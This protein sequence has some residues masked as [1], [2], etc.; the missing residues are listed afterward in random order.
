MTAI[1]NVFKGLSSFDYHKLMLKKEVIIY[2]CDN[3]SI[4]NIAFM[5]GKNINIFLDPGT[6]GHMSKLSSGSNLGIRG[7]VSTGDRARGIA[8]R[9]YEKTWRTL[10]GNPKQLAMIA[11]VVIHEMRHALY[12]HLRPDVFWDL[13][14]EHSAQQHNSSGWMES[15]MEVSQYVTTNAL[16]FVAE[17]FTGTMCGTS[18][19]SKVL[20]GY[21]ALGGP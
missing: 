3:F 13:K 10:L 21:Q 20:A 9:R 4:K 18:Y 5:N 16:E 8:D 17:T 15:P 6:K 7:G 1:D 2:L 12:E 11:A 14:R 19:D